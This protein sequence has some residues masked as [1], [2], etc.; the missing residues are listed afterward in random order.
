M[1]CCRKKDEEGT[2]QD[3][4]TVAQEGSEG[5]ARGGGRGGV[6]RRSGPP[7]RNAREKLRRDVRYPG[8][9]RLQRAL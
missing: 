9:S 5:M 1:G 6:V 2:A 8:P 7:S 4:G 3:G